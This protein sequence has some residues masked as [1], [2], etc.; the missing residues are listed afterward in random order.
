MRILSAFAVNNI[1]K[2]KTVYKFLTL[3]REGYTNH[4]AILRRYIQSMYSV[5]NGSK[6]VKFVI[7]E[8][9]PGHWIVLK[10]ISE[11]NLTLRMKPTC[12]DESMINLDSF[13]IQRRNYDWAEPENQG[14]VKVRRARWYFINRMSIPGYPL[15]YCFWDILGV[16]CK[17]IKCFQILV[18][19]I[20]WRP[21]VYVIL[22]NY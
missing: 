21:F 6:F 17:I 7:V 18:I 5:W 4:E 19:G 11:E 15:A 13:K 3:G 22:F 9:N 12:K 14:E 10:N 16:W 20:N 1:T 2:C 8:E